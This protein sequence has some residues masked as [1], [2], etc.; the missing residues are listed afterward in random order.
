MQSLKCRYRGLG[1]IV[2]GLALF[3]GIASCELLE[4]DP[5]TPVP[6]PDIVDIIDGGIVMG[7]VQD[8]AGN[9][10]GEMDVRIGRVDTR[11]NDQEW[12]IAVGLPA[13]ERV[14]LRATLAGYGDAYDTV[15]ILDGDTTGVELR[16]GA[17]D[18]TTSVDP[19][20]G[21]AVVSGTQTVTFPR[22]PL[23]TPALARGSRSRSTSR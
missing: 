14:I 8:T 19:A 10:L 11:T 2:V 17:V 1:I 22:T 23:S 15:A 16:M 20:T 18:V 7:I 4:S 21:G 9:P 3:S 5:A 12:F 6:T 13:S